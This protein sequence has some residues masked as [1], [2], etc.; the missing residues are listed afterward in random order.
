MRYII[1]H[2]RHT[3]SLLLLFSNQTLTRHLEFGLYAENLFVY[4]ISPISL[5]FKTIVFS[6]SFPQFLEQY[7]LEYGQFNPLY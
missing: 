1:T 4:F 3:Q 6:M 5:A 2:D 7:K